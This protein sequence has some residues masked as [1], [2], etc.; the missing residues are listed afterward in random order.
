M[1]PVGLTFQL[2]TQHGAWFHT[3]VPWGGKM[4]IGS[5][6]HPPRMSRRES[7]SCP[8][9]SYTSPGF[10][11]LCT[12]QSLCTVIKGWRIQCS[13]WP[14]WSWAPPE[15]NG[16]SGVTNKGFNMH[17]GSMSYVLS[18]FAAGRGRR[19]MTDLFWGFWWPSQVRFIPRYFKG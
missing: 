7:V 13:H 18:K 6:L 8:G 10:C 9:K 17:R 1:A 19:E 5:G 4:A 16:Q 15:P 14:G 11:P 12:N 2:S 3:Y